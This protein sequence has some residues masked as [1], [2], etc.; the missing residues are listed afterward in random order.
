MLG[1][2][3]LSLILYTG[4]GCQLCE[5]AQAMFL[6]SA[7]AG[8]WML[9]IVSVRTTPALYHQYGARIP[10]FLRTDTNA[11]LAWPFAL[12]ELELFLQ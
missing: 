11:E 3:P 4:P 12:A 10:V 7:A 9:D 5:K 8:N 1:I 6:Q 2:S